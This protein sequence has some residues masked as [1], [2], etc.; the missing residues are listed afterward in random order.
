VLLF[1]SADRIDLGAT[2]SRALLGL[3]GVPTAVVMTLGACYL[4]HRSV[5]S[6]S[7]VLGLS[8]MLVLASTAA[9]LAPLLVAQ[10]GA[11]Q[12]HDVLSTSRARWCWSVLAVLA[13]DLVAVLCAIAGSLREGAAAE[14]EQPSRQLG[15]NEMGLA[16]AWST[17][18]ARPR[19]VAARRVAAIAPRTQT[20]QNPVGGESCV[21]CG[22]TDFSSRKAVAGHQRTCRIPLP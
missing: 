9:L 10:L 3:S 5:A 2:W 7:W 21:R 14:H 18:A 22:R 15:A 4:G 6:R 17:Q 8:T 20:E 11:E 1:L 13:P 16:G 12:I 19:A